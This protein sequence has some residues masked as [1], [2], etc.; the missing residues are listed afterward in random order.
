M[1]G[2]GDRYDVKISFECVQV[3]LFFRHLV[4]PFLWGSFFPTPPPLTIPP[5]CGTPYAADGSSSG[6]GEGGGV[7]LSEDLVKP[8]VCIWISSQ[9]GV[10][11]MACRWYS[12]PQPLMKFKYTLQTLVRLN[13]ALS[14][15]P[16]LGA[17]QTTSC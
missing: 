12:S 13:V 4:L 8:G 16:H 7:E 15:Q 5:A 14:P 2:G 9:H 17:G 11:L 6:Q 3:H 10:L 1:W